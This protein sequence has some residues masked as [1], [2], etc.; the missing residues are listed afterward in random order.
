MAVFAG[1]TVRVQFRG[2]CFGQRII[3]DL[4]YRVSVG[5]PGITTR[6]ALNAI[7]QAVANGLN[8]PVDAYL[9]C[10]PAQYTLESVRSQIVKEA[11]SAFNDLVFAPARAGTNPG[12]AT[13]SC[14]SA[15]IVRRTALAG[16]NQVSVLKVGPC[17]DGASAAGI[18]TPEYRALL[19]AFGSTTLATFIAGA[20]Q[21]TLVP[22]ILAP[23]GTHTNRDL[24]SLDIGATS[25]VM[26]RRVVG[27]GE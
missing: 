17:P 24:E 1:D 11:R 18:L 15:A 12:G 5:N 14:D 16:R 21:L 2:R 13:V 20:T 8:N 3:L 23:D 7:N 22:T 26:R 25:R 27:N 4:G 9:A 10:L 6:A 19:G